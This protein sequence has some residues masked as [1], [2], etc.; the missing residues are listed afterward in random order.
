L[1]D[2]LDHWSIH[3]E[4]IYP[5]HVERN[6]ALMREAV[7][8]TQRG[9]AV[10]V[11]TVEQDLPKWLRFFVDSGGDLTRLTASSDAAISSPRT[12]FEQIRCCA[13][14]GFGLEAVLP[15]ITSNPARVLKFASK[16]RIEKGSSADV[17]LLDR[18]SLEITDVI[19]R[20]NHLLRDG[21]LTVTPA[22]LLESNRKVEL[23]GRKT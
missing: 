11:D 20:G 19:A 3:P 14:Q 23:N 15:L 4:W 7:S 22:F 17:V 16:G 13:M 10:D 18:Q 1:R 2:L 21:Q 6:E 9:V 5:T 8:L 12:L